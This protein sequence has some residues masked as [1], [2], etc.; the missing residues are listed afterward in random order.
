VVLPPSVAPMPNAL[1]P[2]SSAAV[3]VL[4]MCPETK[5][6]AVVLMGVG[7]GFWLFGMNYIMALL[8]HGLIR[9]M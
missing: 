1:R 6:L 3:N 8:S 4:A 9:K 7:Q 5:I 2:V